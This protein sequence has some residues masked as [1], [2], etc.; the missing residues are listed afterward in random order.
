MMESMHVFILC[1]ECI[2][3]WTATEVDAAERDRRP[4]NKAKSSKFTVEAKMQM[5]QK[6]D[7]A[8][9]AGNMTQKQIA[10]IYG[11]TQKSVSTIFQKTTEILAAAASLSERDVKKRTKVPQSE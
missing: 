3:E 1:L 10:E 11:Y 4:L 6:Y 7:K 9:E 5:I 2:C 8:L